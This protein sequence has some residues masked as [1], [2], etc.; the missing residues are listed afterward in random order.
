MAISELVSTLGLPVLGNDSEQKVWTTRRQTKPPL[1]LLH[2]NCVVEP[3]VELLT[4]LTIHLPAVLAGL[5]FMHFYV[6]V[7]G[8]VDTKVSNYNHI[9]HKTCLFISENF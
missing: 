3:P 5:G 8:G 6:L 7:S 2:F 4:A 1:R 9:P